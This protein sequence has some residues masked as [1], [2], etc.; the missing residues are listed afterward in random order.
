LIHQIGLSV[1]TI[2]ALAT[3]GLVISLYEGPRALLP[4]I[5]ALVVMISF[6]MLRE[7]IRRFFF[8]ELR[9]KEVLVFDCI[10]AGIQIAGLLLFVYLDLLSANLAYWI[11]GIACGMVTISWFIP[12]RNAFAIE[13]KKVLS[14]LAHNWAFAKWVFASGVLWTISMNLYP[15][16]L[17]YFIGVDA[18]GIWGACF[19]VV[20]LNN[21]LFFG[22]QNLLGPQ[23]AH[24][25][26]NGG[27]ISLRRITYRAV[28]IFC[29]VLMLF[30][31]IIF[32]FGEPLIVL[33]YGNKYAGNALVVYILALNLIPLAAGFCFSRSLFTLERADI[34]F[35]A[36][37]VVLFVLCSFGLWLVKYF[38][39]L[40][41]AYGLLVS[42]ISVIPVRY[43]A[44]NRVF[45]SL[46]DGQKK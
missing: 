27:I 39:V 23:I 34:D 40:G 4:V 30:C 11:A 9:M 35:F 16:F 2:V 37:F 13:I 1:L 22:L 15:W 20:A 5:W 32:L 29:S 18:V 45:E 3:S 26:A 12:N 10:V 42:N 28:I 25:Y 17:A 31:G 36:N 33:I 6:I 21:P 43:F 38:G 24:S 7:Y 41:A 46:I 19:G 14:D 8:A 44:L